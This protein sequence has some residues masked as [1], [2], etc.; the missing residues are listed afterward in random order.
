MSWNFNSATNRNTEYSI[1]Q[2]Q[3]N[4][5]WQT[6]RFNR[7]IIKCIL[8]VYNVFRYFHISK[9]TFYGKLTEIGFCISHSG[10]RTTL[11]RSR[12][13]IVIDQRHLG[14]PM[15]RHWFH[16][17]IYRSITMPMI[18]CNDSTDSICTFAFWTRWNASNIIPHC[19]QNTSLDRFQPI[20]NIRDESTIQN[21]N[22]ISC[23][24]AHIL[25]MSIYLNYIIFHY[26]S[27]LNYY[28]N[29]HL[30]IKLHKKDLVDFS[31]RPLA[32]AQK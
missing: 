21:I 15:I 14:L 27:L 22:T 20:P 8:P 13:R 24:I 32:N 18:F 1:H 25:L 4:L 29:I 19:I 30:K 5:N 31:T 10:L 23:H 17:F 7:M 11:N 26:I 3:R 2:K 28:Y 16:R 6:F 9:Q 12:V